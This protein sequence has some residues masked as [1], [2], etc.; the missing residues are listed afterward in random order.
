MS[1]LKEHRGGASLKFDKL[2]DDASKL[3]FAWLKKI[4]WYAVELLY[5]EEKWEKL[6]EIISRFTALTK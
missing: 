2:L 4:I 3:Q 6:A 5:H 1:E